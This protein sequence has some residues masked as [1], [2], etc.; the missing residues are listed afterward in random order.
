MGSV[1]ER[2]AVIVLVCLLATA[3][4]GIVGPSCTDESGPVA[5][6]D[7]QVAARETV[8][9]TVVSPKHSNLILRLTWPDTAATLGLRATITECGQHIGCLMDTVSPAFGP[10]G[11]SPT[12]QPWPPGVLEMLVDGTRGKTYRVDVVGD[13]ERVASFSLRVSYRITCEN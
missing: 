11:P 1:H 7:G 9:H 5:S 10:G 3:S 2:V 4:C 6:A 8:A 13:T 12:P